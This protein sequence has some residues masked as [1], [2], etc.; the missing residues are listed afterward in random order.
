MDDATSS[1]INLKCGIPQGSILGTILFVLY[2]SPLGNL[3]GLHEI[4]PQ[5][6]ADDQQIYLAFK[7]SIKGSQEKCMN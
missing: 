7:P 6:Y 1:P 4:E 2:T 3:C 5:F